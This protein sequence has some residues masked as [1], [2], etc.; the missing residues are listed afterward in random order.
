MGFDMSRKDHLWLSYAALTRAAAQDAAE[1]DMDGNFPGRAFD[2][3]RALGV[4]RSPPIAAA[5]SKKLLQVLAAIGRGN[6]SVGRIF[7]G[8]CN[9]LL[10]IDL[11]G[12]TQQRANVAHLLAGGAIFGVW[13]TDVP[14]APVTLTDNRLSGKKNYASGIDGLSHAVITAPI[15]DKRQMLLLPVAHLPV[16]RTWWKP[17]GM[18]ASGSHIVSFDGVTVTDEARLGHADDYITEPWFSSGAIRF[19]AVQVGGMH[20]ILD[21]AAAHLRAAKR[22]HNPHQIH[23]VGEMGVAVATGYRWLDYVA[24]RWTKLGQHHAKGLVISANAA[25]VAVERSALEVL[26]LA[27]RSVGA[28]GMI[29]PHPLER[30]IRDLRTYLRQ[31]NP[32]GALAD[33]GTA[34]LEEAWTPDDA[35]EY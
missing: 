33:V 30:L 6:L 11:F 29:S 27:E 22:S 5:N 25:R 3:L 21:V 35:S 23:R 4:V 28:S 31:P 19:L 1:R 26:E 12:T 18:K 8:H 13:N 9:A 20:A 34:I 10:L 2:Q 17:L 16:D 14:Q 24:E 15:A 7:E 32:D